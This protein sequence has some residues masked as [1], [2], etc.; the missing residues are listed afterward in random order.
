MVTVSGYKVM[1]YVNTDN[2]AGI[3]LAGGKSSRMGRDKAQIQYMGKSLLDHMYSLLSCSD[4][5]QIYVSGKGEVKDII[6][7]CGPLGGIYSVLQKS[8]EQ[9]LIIIPVDMPLLSVEILKNLIETEY[10]DADAVRYKNFNFP[11]K[12]R[13]SD[14]LNEEIENRVKSIKSD[15]SISSLLSEF[16]VKELPLELY[17]KDNFV[18]VNTYDE[19]EKIL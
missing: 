17:Q 1:R 15:L 2:I 9:E 19:L 13:V 4:I 14:R 11:L 18:N 16:N 10:A 7:E 6:P 5:E 3:V 8:N 12:I